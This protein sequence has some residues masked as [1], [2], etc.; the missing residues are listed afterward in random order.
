MYTS[1]IVPTGPPLNVSVIPLNATS[2]YVSWRPPQDDLI[3]GV[4]TSYS[5]QL[6]EVETSSTQIVNSVT[7][8]SVTVGG[9]HPNYNYRVQVAAVTTGTGPYSNISLVQ[10]PVSSEFYTI[11]IGK[12][13]AL[14]SGPSGSP[15]GVTG[16]STSP[17][18]ITISWTAPE[19]G[20]LNGAVTGYIINVTHSDTLVS[21]Q[22][23]S[24]STSLVI[25][26]LEPYTTYI[27][28]VAAQT[29]AG[30]GPFSLLILI[31]TQETG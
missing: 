1:H 10:L 2:L 23:S 16:A 7:G 26:N 11:R 6:F 28:V 13:C 15:T 8:L 20:L 24:F 31:Q 30:N 25:N 9:L 21:T 29:S 12:Y 3:N 4:I 17:Y 27:C 14:C 22:Y 18:S 19:P 5:V